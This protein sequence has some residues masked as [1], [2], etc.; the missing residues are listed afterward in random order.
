MTQTRKSSG[1]KRLKTEGRRPEEE[2]AESEDAEMDNG[3]LTGEN[4]DDGGEDETDA[5]PVRM[6]LGEMAAATA[7]REAEASGG[8][9]CPKCGCGHLR[10]SNTWNAHGGRSRKRTCRHCGHVFPTVERIAP[11]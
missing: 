6:T 7:A 5:G 10:V 9:R 11:E 1:K 4:E 2:D 8:I 3:Q